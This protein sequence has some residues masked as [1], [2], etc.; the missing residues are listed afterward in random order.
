MIPVIDMHCDTISFLEKRDVKAENLKKGGRK[1]KEGDFSFTFTEE[2]MKAPLNLRE[3]HC[4]V[5]LLRMKSA[6]YMCQCFALYTSRQAAD[7]ADMEPFR[8][9]MRLSDRLDREVAEN[10]DLIRFAY[11][12]KDIEKNF[13]EGY[14][15][16]LK[17]VEEGIPYEGKIENLYKAYEKG[18]RKSTLT[19]NFENELAFPNPAG[20]CRES[21]QD[22][23]HALDKKNGLKK[24]GFA[25][26]EAMED[27][28][29]VIDISHLN[30]A[31]IMDIFSVIKPS[32][33]IVASHSN[34]RGAAFHPRNLS[35]E[36]LKKLADHGGIT[37]INFCG[38]FLNETY[39]DNKPYLSRIEDMIR[40][41]E[42][43]RNIAGIDT[44]GLGSDFD[45]ITGDLEVNGAGEMPKIAEAMDRAGFT[46][47]EIEKVYWKNAM[48]V[49]REV[50][51]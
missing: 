22:K 16:A 33:P 11:S 7:E 27:M 29:M 15:S 37:G 13:E 6:G 44:I 26:I 31:G 45:G 43:I 39:I 40:H 25:F 34:A 36:M 28:G 50:L 35:D 21:L 18:V 17:T 48:R 32:T 2:D 51:R 19:W 24:T 3:N 4:M 23:E 10:S 47:E 1:E 12:A 5:D 41:M 46:D 49:Y 30:D 14:L 20:F 8:Y 9:L 38:P 42:Y